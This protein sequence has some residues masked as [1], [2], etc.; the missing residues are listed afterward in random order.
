M[1]FLLA[2]AATLGLVPA[3]ANPQSLRF[4]GNGV[5]DIDRVKI[6]LEAPNR[7]ANIGAGDFTI[8]L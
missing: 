7:P 1:R 4:F 8:D 6:P 2:A 3:S 5:G